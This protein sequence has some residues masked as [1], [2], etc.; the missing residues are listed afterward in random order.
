MK[1]VTQQS[2]IEAESLA[3][4]AALLNAV[5][6]GEAT[7]ED[8]RP[9]LWPLPT[10]GGADPTWIDHSRA[11]I[12]SWDRTHF[13]VDSQK[14]NGVRCDPLKRF[15]LRPRS[16][17]ANSGAPRPAWGDEPA[18]PAPS[19]AVLPQSAHAAP[20]GTVEQLRHMVEWARYAHRTIREAKPL[21]PEAAVIYFDLHVL[22][23]ELQ[24]SST[25]LLQELAP[26]VQ[27]PK[28]DERPT[29]RLLSPA[30]T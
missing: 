27:L 23:G 5:H 24:R 17:F 11:M 2:L 13:L 7:F 8:E 12:F 15:L 6:N 29:L 4:L 30:R 20:F 10:F 1:I 18:R 16:H 19:L 22:A 28:K 25:E 21:P 14:T 3:C 9:A 26:V